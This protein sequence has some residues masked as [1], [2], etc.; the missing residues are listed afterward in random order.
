LLALA[1]LPVLWLLL[2][3]TPPSPRRQAFPAIRLV[4]GLKAPEETPARTPWWLLLLRMLV[5][6]LIILGLSQPLLNPSRGLTGSGPLVLVIDDGWTAARFWSAR[7]SAMERLL[8]Q[9]DREARPVIL[10]TTAPTAR[11]EVPEPSPELPA[12][13]AQRLAQALKPKPWPVNRFAVLAAVKKLRLAGSAHVVWL[14][15]GLDDMVQA[16]SR[17]STVALAQALRRL[18]RL[19]ILRDSGPGLAR[20]MLP[21]DS[22]G[23]V[24]IPRMQRAAGDAEE[25]AAVLSIAEDGRVISRTEVAFEAGE[26]IGRGRLE[27]PAELRNRIASLRIEGENTAGAVMLLDERWRRRPV[28]M[29]TIGA[30]VEAQ[31][32]LSESY[33]LARALEPFTELRRGSIEELLQRE[34]AVLI[35]P[36]GAGAMEAGQLSRVEAWVEEGGLLLRFSGPH[37]AESGGAL[38][39]VTLRGGD[40]I[41]GGAMTWDS[42]ARLAP[43]DPASPFAGIAVPDDVLVEQ[44]VLAEP[45]LELGEKTWARLSDGTPLVTAD[46]RGAGWL[47]LIHTSANTAWSN[48]SLSG[49][50]VDML[51]RILNVSQ[52]VAAEDA[53]GEALAPLET[54][55]GFG[56]LGSPP[57]HVLALTGEE[58]EDQDWGI[59]PRHPPGYYGT[60]NQRRAHNLG[61][62]D[63]TLTP[64]GALPSGVSL[65]D[66]GR[67]QESD[68]KPWLL[69]AAL[70]LALIDLLISLFLRGFSSLRGRGSAAGTAVVLLA[71]AMGLADAAQAQSDDRRYL[72]ASLSTRLAYVE[73]GVPHVD[74]TSRAG[75]GG[76]T[77]TLQRRTSI[78]AG[79]PLAVDLDS[80][81][82]SFFPLL[83]WPVTNQQGRLSQLARQKVND[84]LK[85]GG[86]ILFD[87][88]EA[89]AGTQML[90]QM[91]RGSEA[92]Q[93][94]GEGLEIPNLVPVPPDHVLTKSFYLM[95]TF[96]G[97]FTGGTLWVEAGADTIND[98]VASVLVGSNDWAGAW[99]VDRLGQPVNALVPD[100]ARQREMAYRFGVN[101]VMYALTGNYKADQVHVPF[102]LER[103][104]Q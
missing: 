4:S 34:L 104:G 3:V 8:G 46:R 16:S 55:D 98:G 15:D 91:S 60:N 51:Q 71:L 84:Y 37:L 33:Y 86:T 35:L 103:L 78:E 21:P 77:L 19:D 100:G 92:L 74:E 10:L 11:G 72:E 66:Y 94:L 38:L 48:L 101:L 61:D 68:L 97:R 41:L 27:L 13:E 67:V 22:E 45:S 32:L 80:D 5:A 58:G 75:L 31:P 85:N 36:D 65:E 89:R 54:L 99:A 102:I 47:V 20:V 6:A 83:Y 63:F 23:L 64:I 62:Q 93:R 59:G 39:P 14:S 43:F 81:D 24:I 29:V 28:G 18:G 69:A 7:L 49:I 12:T 57:P 40:R 95:Q 25:R 76:L 79:T 90:G 26:T 70:L 52:G 96:P 42:P 87:L 82:L 53:A 56:V 50:F 17:S 1:G 9:A 2:R 44:Q 30:L 88:R 73:T